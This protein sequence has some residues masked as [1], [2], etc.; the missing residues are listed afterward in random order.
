MREIQFLLILFLLLGL[1]LF[2]IDQAIDIDWVVCEDS[3]VIKT[4]WSD[5]CEKEFRFTSFWFDL[6]PLSPFYNPLKSFF[7]LK[8]PLSILLSYFKGISP[9]WRPP[10]VRLIRLF[11]L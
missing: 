8:N 11:V 5:T 3:I 4:E 9:F 10:P 2:Q 6:R 7:Q 1:P